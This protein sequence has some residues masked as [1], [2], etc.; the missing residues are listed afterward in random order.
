[1]NS[2][3]ID[4]L[5]ALLH[6]LHAVNNHAALLKLIHAGVMT[7][8]AITV[9]L[10]R[11]WWLYTGVVGVVLSPDR[12]LSQ[13]TLDYCK[14]QQHQH[15]SHAKAQ[16]QYVSIPNLHPNVIVLYAALQVKN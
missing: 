12:R 5:H 13:P 11:C 2:T 10:L 4:M 6:A 15:G 1:M 9:D 8:E 7:V 16:S 3:R 14:Q